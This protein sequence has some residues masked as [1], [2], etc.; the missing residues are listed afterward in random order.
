V[1]GP[2]L[3]GLQEVLHAQKAAPA[4]PQAR[5]GK[6]AWCFL[7]LSLMGLTSVPGRTTT[8]GRVA[9]RTTEGGFQSLPTGIRSDRSYCSRDVNG[10]GTSATRSL[11]TTDEKG[12]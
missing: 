3:G 5:V 9:S 7:L 4:T 8:A 1:I 6:T 2:I 10:Y 12:A 11:S